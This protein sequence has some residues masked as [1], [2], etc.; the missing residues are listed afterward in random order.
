[1]PAKKGKIFPSFEGEFNLPK[2]EE[3]VLKFWKT[4][5]IFEKSLKKN[6]GKKRFVFYEGPPY[7]NGRP[8]IH[9]VLARVVKDVILRFR[10]MQGYFV[11]RRAGWDT[12]GLPVEIAAEKALG[13]KSKR[14][15]E[16]FGIAEFNKK[17]KEFVWIYKDEWENMTERIGYWLD[18]KNAYITYENKYIETLWWILKRIWEKK[19]LQKSHK[20]VPWCTRCGTALS[21]HELAQ[22]Y[23]DIEENSVYIKFK[24]VPGQKFGKFKTDNN[25]YVLSWTTTPWTLPGNVALAVGEKIEYSLVGS[26][27]EKYIV[28]ADLKEKVVKEGDVMGTVPGRA[29]VGLK[30]KQLFD[31]PSLKNPKA[32]S[33][34]GA[35]FVTTTDG[36]GVVHTAVMYGEDDYR[37]GAKVGL[38][39]KHTVDDT[40]RFTKDVKGLSG[41]YVKEEAT[42]KKIIAI[43]KKNN[44]L[45]RTEPYLHEYP[46][47][48]RCGTAVIYYVR[49]SWFITM[50]KLREDLLAQNKKIN[51]LPSHLKEGRFGEWLRE[52]K[53]WNLSRERYWGTPL[54]IWECAKCGHAEVLGS[55]SELN[56]AAGGAKNE[57]WIMRHGEAQGNVKKIIDS[58][59]Q[60]FHLTKKG[61]ISAR[62]AAKKLKTAEIDIIFSSPLPR[63]K[64]TAKIVAQE[65][66]IKKIIF[67]TRLREINL[68]E[69]SG[70]P[71]KEYGEI[72]PT[73]KEKFEKNVGP[74]SESLRDVRKRVWEFIKE[75]EKKHARKRILVVSHGD[76]LCMFSEAA[77]GWSEEETAVKKMDKQGEFI[78]LGE[79]RK[80]S[81]G[82]FPRNETGEADFHKPFI[83]EIKINCPKCRA[84]V[85]RVKE[86]ADVWFDSGA[87]PFA[88]N[89]YPFENKDS[90][91]KKKMY[92]ADYIAEG[93]D[94]TRGWFYTLLAEA[95]ALGYRAPYKNVVSL[96][97]INDKF[98]QKMSKSKGNVVDPW[99]VI[100]KFGTDALRWYLFTAAPLGE[101]KNFDEAEVGK[102]FRKIHLIVWNSLAF[103]KTYGVP[104]VT[105]P[106][107]KNILDRWMLERLDECSKDV[108]G[109]LGNYEIRE[110]ALLIETL[111]DDLSRW[112]IR[113][114][115]RRFQRSTNPTDLAAASATLRH[116]LHEL[117][118]LMAPFSPFFAEA[119]YSSAGGGKESVHLDGWTKTQEAPKSDLVSLM[120]EV[121]KTA[122]DALAKRAE[123]GIK[124]RQPLKSLT[125][126]SQA[127][128]KQK[129]LLAILKEEVNVKEI[130]FNSALNE[131]LV[132][133]TVITPQLKEEGV[134]RELTRMV[135]DLRQKA[136]YRPQD[137]IVLLAEIHGIFSDLL[138]RNEKFM[139]TEVGAKSIE[140]KRGKKFG[141]EA[142]TKLEGEPIWL[143]VRKV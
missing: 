13:I 9:H 41:K 137:K 141:A 104:G 19:L 133:D 125:L 17:A 143:A 73:T 138:K 8:G 38:P 3:E 20:V 89:H 105:K 71:I 77:L 81:L 142:E 103:L 42:E 75:I 83:D 64:E 34:Y 112:Y 84:K 60:N 98:G 1:M 66:G 102:V 65:L 106:Q 76:T 40:G 118:K 59:D 29:L 116:I 11:P 68:G 32:H 4:N 43:L 63:T 50:T 120:A 62:A 21:S 136:G 95:T 91:D 123:L 82:V 100:N 90:V 48:W 115:R 101:P 67:D 45:L 107:A 92:P 127:L 69:L 5:Q 47:C 18:L 58:G 139:K 27:K 16:K 131:E 35:D 124:V 113:R 130:F 129:E 57:Y 140:Y 46:F 126:K 24:L 99:A 88:Q 134:L 25:T 51:W 122:S 94:Q 14:D 61:E 135:Q 15:I 54:P 36:T 85:S 96:G 97:L 56:A 117:S 55:A 33:I 31:V 23:R 78:N 6:E 87:M 72:L 128:K 12:H 109:K 108:F 70:R 52:V 132:L 93:M 74:K 110:A 111:I 2:T 37:L 28:A 119:L 10:S 49:D 86:I 114:S 79:V 30:Y 44:Q 26:G 22:G 7:A 121:R 80:V 53:D 39:Q